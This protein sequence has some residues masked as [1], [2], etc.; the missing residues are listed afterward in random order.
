MR[1]LMNEGYLELPGNWRDRTVHALL[2]AIPEVVGSNLVL[3]RDELPYG[4]EF[5]DYVDVQKSRFKRE[6]TD[7]QMQHDSACSVDARPGHCLE[8]NWKQESQVMYQLALIILDAPAILTL[9]Y[10][11]PGQLPE[12]V[13]QDMTAAMI[14]FKFHRGE[15]AQA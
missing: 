8:F 15:A 14:G 9:T 5:A 3:T 2:P 4:A 1:Y 12:Q 6:L 7:L 10:T 13:R 11:S